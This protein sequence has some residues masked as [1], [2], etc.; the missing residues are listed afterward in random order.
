MMGIRQ[1]SDREGTKQTRAMDCILALPLSPMGRLHDQGMFS[2]NIP[3][4]FFFSQYSNM[5]QLSSKF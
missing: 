2:Q 1:G 4:F 5:K 3:F